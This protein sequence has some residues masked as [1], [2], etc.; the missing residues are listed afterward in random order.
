MH[1]SVMYMKKGGTAYM[2]PFAESPF[3]WMMQRAFFVETFRLEC[4]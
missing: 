2:T 3:P 1:P 4:I